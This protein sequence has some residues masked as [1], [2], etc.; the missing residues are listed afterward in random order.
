MK[1]EEDHST[2]PLKR[3]KLP[4]TGL[5]SCLTLVATVA[6]MGGTGGFVLLTWFTLVCAGPAAMPPFAVFTVTACALVPLK[7][8][9]GKHGR[10]PT[11]G[12]VTAKIIPVS[13]VVALVSWSGVRTVT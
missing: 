2:S 11:V 5:G 12:V 13:S 7:A 10:V 6:V 1:S 8:H 9:Q 3:S 4:V